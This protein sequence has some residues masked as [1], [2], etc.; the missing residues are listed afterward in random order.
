MGSRTNRREFLTLAAGGTAVAVF[1]RGSASRAATLRYLPASA[2]AA[3]GGGVQRFRSRPDLLAPEVVI[4]TPAQA[5][6]SGVI[7]TESHAG[8]PQSG[9]LIV[10]Q[11]GRIVWFNPLAPS[12][13][14]PLRAF[15]VRVQQYHG[16]PVLCWFEGVVVGS[17][18]IGYG[19]GNYKIVD[20]SYQQIAEVSAQDGYQGDLHEFL[21]TPQ[22]TALFT[23]Y[24]RAEGRVRSGGR[25]RRVPYLFGVVQEVDVATG[26]LLWHWRTDRH[27]P[28]TESH[29]KPVLKPGWE[30]DYFH[31]N[32]ISIDPA[33][34]NLVISGR[35]TC[36]CYKVNRRT[37][38]VMW[39]LGGKHSDF[40]MD[41]GT[42]F[43]FQH[44]VNIHPGG[45]LTLFDNE[46]GPPQEAAESRALVLSVDE[47]RRRVRLEHAFHHSPPVYSDA[48]GSVQP[49]GHGK[50]FVGW[51]RSTNFTEY[52]GTGE[53]MFD[54]HLSAGS[55]SYRA[56]LR[57]WSGTPTA[58]PDVAVARAGAD[59][60]LYAS[61]NGASAMAQWIVL[62]GPSATQLAPLGIAPIAGFE[63]AIS[64]ASAPAFLAVSAADASGQVL[65]T[66]RVVTAS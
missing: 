20:T 54:G 38:K 66:S 33:D 17:H 64:V 18:G 60:T 5:R 45:V 55:S 19:Q 28:L 27:V 37:G 62:G 65:A 8:P 23:C 49:L 30:W 53:V 31:V 41:P 47:K 57:S 24:G 22:G 51:G 2:S 46:G 63:T 25:M 40:Q 3:V 48:L 6:L 61:W 9:P 16:Q 56:F 4:D 14:S 59:A 21:L 58:P 42:R 29:V 7:V 34:Q 26:K 10:D 50:W 36:A 52:A 35:N 32:A 39:R 11:T 12:P 1:G 15:N 43:T 13:E 44:D